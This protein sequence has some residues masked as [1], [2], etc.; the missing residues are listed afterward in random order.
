MI[1]RLI[2]A[3]ATALGLGAAAPA[4]AAADPAALKTCIDGLSPDART[5]YTAVAPKVKPDSVIPDLL[6]A[7]VRPMVMGG[8]LT[9]SAAKASAPAAGQC[10]AMLK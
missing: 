2:V 1:V 7:T 8:K 10:L 4:L 6:R 3:A 5:I 9:S